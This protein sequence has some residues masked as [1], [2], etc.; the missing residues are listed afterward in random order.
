[1]EQVK[2]NAYKYSELNEDAKNNVS[3]KYFL[4]GFEY[5]DDIN[6]LIVI[7]YDYFEEWELSEQ[8]D[9]CNANDYLFSEDGVMINHLIMDK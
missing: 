5:E 4:D 7:K 1:M 2:I 8:I 9:F 3:Y 6:G